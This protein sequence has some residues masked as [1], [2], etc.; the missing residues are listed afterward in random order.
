MSNLSQKELELL[1]KEDPELYKKVSVKGDKTKQRWGKSTVA[2]YYKQLHAEEIKPVVDAMLADKESA[3]FVS[4]KQF[5]HVTPAT[6]C[7]RVRQGFLFLVDNMDPKGLYKAAHKLISVSYD[8]SGITLTWNFNKVK[9][10]VH[11][12][13]ISSEPIEAFRPETKKHN[14]PDLTQAI[15]TSV[16]DKEI[17]HDWRVSLE[18][19]LDNPEAEEL[20]LDDLELSQEEVDEIRDSLSGAL[21]ITH[22]ITRNSIKLKRA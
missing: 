18:D 20:M 6:A 22:S 4:I 16:Y 11:K 1:Q 9:R 8:A 21:R 17:M 10:T 7:Q 13:A 14:K 5:K 2:P 3:Q 19:F 15:S 12:K